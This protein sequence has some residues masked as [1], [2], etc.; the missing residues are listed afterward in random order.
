MR[1]EI[2][3]A[4]SVHLF[5]DTEGLLKSLKPR[6]RKRYF[7]PAVRETLPWVM[8]CLPHDCSVLWTVAGGGVRHTDV[9]FRGS[10]AA[11]ESCKLCRILEVKILICFL[12]QRAKVSWAEPSHRPYRLADFAGALKDCQNPQ[13]TQ[14][15][16]ALK[17]T[18]CRLSESTWS[19]VF[20]TSLTK[21]PTIHYNM[22]VAL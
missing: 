3:M 5:S 2:R 16:G 8:L 14:S 9:P 12:L 18:L 10:G 19:A 17:R 21:L 6:Q 13:W 11:P 1:W 15:T 7:T 4:S 20:T 22:D